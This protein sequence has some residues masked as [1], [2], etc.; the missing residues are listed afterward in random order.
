MDTPPIA[1]VT[2]AILLTKF[3]QSVIFVV[4]QNYSTRDVLDLVD[5]LHYK[6]GIKNVGI[7][8]NDVKISSYYGYG[9]KYNY[10]YGYGYG[11]YYGYGEEY[12]GEIE[13]KLTPME[14]VI[15]FLFK[16]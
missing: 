9:R 16:S 12:Y 14:K 10:G 4:R 15:R 11:Y 5:S 2:D 3:S 13:R 6:R 1:I 7:L 8:I